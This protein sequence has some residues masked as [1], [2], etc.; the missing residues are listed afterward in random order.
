MS[1]PCSEKNLSRLVLSTYRTCSSPKNSLTF[2][3]N[4]LF[5]GIFFTSS[6]A[7]LNFSASCLAPSILR[8]ESSSAAFSCLRSSATFFLYARRFHALRPARPAPVTACSVNTMP[9][10]PSAVVFVISANF[11]LCPS[12]VLIMI[13]AKSPSG[14]FAMATDM[15]LT[16]SWRFSVITSPPTANKFP[17]VSFINRERMI[18]LVAILFRLARNFFLIPRPSSF[19]APPP[20]AVPAVPIYS[21]DP[22]MNPPNFEKNSTSSIG[23]CLPSAPFVSN[24]SNAIP[25]CS[26]L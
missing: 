9:P 12:N 25:P 17:P 19:V 18:G 7:L 26:I 8:R 2:S 6:T 24:I 15:S 21:S 14:F 4:F 5:N 10:V 20:A 11:S 13:S 22:A 3:G 23:M 16:I 1:N